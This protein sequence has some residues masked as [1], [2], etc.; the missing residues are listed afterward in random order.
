MRAGEIIRDAFAGRCIVAF[1][2]V[3]D[4]PEYP[5]W[6]SIGIGLFVVKA[7]RKDFRS[8]K[9]PNGAELR[10]TAKERRIIPEGNH[11]RL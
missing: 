5:G 8:K 10:A 7:K 9:A 3:R 4:L 2:G 6:P 1:S 11:P